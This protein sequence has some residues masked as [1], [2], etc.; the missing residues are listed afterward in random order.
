M[1][2]V[3]DIV[4][5]TLDIND[6]T[7]FL[8]TVNDTPSYN[9]TNMDELKY[10]PSFLQQE[11]NTAHSHDGNHSMK[12]EDTSV[13]VEEVNRNITHPQESNYV[14]SILKDAMDISINE[15]ENNYNN[16]DQNY[17]HTFSFDDMEDV[18]S[19]LLFF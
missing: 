16:K 3:D 18:S 8:D 13:K 2:T 10:F 6:I 1:Q 7:S 11:S 5:H 4:T 17:Y 14:S 15:L 19:N 9:E 12:L